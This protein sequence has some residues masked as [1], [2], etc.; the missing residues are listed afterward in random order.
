MFPDGP[1]TFGVYQSNGKIVQAEDAEKNLSERY[2]PTGRVAQP[3][4]WP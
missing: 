4:D 1:N 3:R 2:R